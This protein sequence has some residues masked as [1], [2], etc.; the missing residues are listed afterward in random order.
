MASKISFFNI[1]LYKKQLKRF[2]PWSLLYGIILFFLLCAFPILSAQD[3]SK[4]EYLSSIPNL[5]EMATLAFVNLVFFAL[6]IGTL[7][8]NYIHSEDAANVLHALPIRR[9]AHMITNFLA[10]LT[11]MAIPVVIPCAITSLFFAIKGSAYIALFVL[12]LCLLSILFAIVSFSLITFCAA[13]AGNAATMPILFIVI[14]CVSL[15]AYK[16]IDIAEYYFIEG[17]YTARFSTIFEWLCPYMCIF[18][19]LI[20]YYCIQASDGDYLYYYSISYSYIVVYVIGALALLAVS[21]LI[22][23]K[24]SL[25]TTGEM[26][27]VKQIAHP[28]LYI[29]AS[30]VGIVFAGFWYIMASEGLPE[31]IICFFIGSLVGYFAMAMILHRK[32]NVFKQRAKGAAIYCV[33]FVILILTFKFDIYGIGSYVPDAEDVSSVTVNYSTYAYD[34]DYIAATI[35][36]HHAVLDYVNSDITIDKTEPYASCW[37]YFNYSMTDG[38][39]VGRNYNFDFAKSDLDDPDSFASKFIA[40]ITNNDNVIL[41]TFRYSDY[42]SS[43]IVGGYLDNYTV[44]AETRYYYDDATEEWVAIESGSAT[45]SYEYISL[46]TEQATTLSD[47]I[48][49]DIGAGSLSSFDFS[50]YYETYEYDEDSG[51]Y[52]CVS[53]LDGDETIYYMQ[54]ICLQYRSPDTSYDTYYNDCD[55]AWISINSNMTNTIA[56]LKELGLIS[57]ETPLIS[58]SDYPDVEYDY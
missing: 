46:T 31:L 38:T 55:S 27:A 36:F 21:I 58:E 57:D 23:R 8:F 16:L 26:L 22:Y 32:F 28:L 50:F 56:A 13:L 9:E 53:L 37:V 34:E 45:I 39:T 33:V 35:E 1:T 47:A 24:R 52:E 2:A 54:S 18:R 49:A 41:D 11:L 42:E 15:W 20:D 40:W 51:T 17:V 3:Y 7:I 19:R 48:L 4:S 29:A 12:Q 6:S 43:W 44:L 10:G 25:E 30:G 5:I 14:N